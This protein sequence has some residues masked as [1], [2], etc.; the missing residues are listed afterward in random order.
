[1]KKEKSKGEIIIYKN[2]SGPGVEVWLGDETVWLSLQQIADLFGRDKSVI[3]RHIRNIFKST[4]LRQNSVVANF[5]T[6][7]AD[8][9][10]Y[11]VDYYN[12][13]M[14]ISIGYRVNSKLGTRFRVWATERLRDYILK[15][16]IVDRKRLA[17][18]QARIKELEATN[19]IFRR[20]LNSRQLTDKEKGLLKVITDYTNTW[21][22]LNKYD[23]GEL[24]FSGVSKKTPLVLKLEEARK[25]IEH[26]K[27]RLIAQKQATDIFGKESNHKLDA[28]LGSIE[29]GF[30]G[31]PAYPS[32]EERAA[33][34]LYFAIKDHPFIDGNKRIGSLLFLLY[35]IENN[36]FFAKNGESK[37]DDNALTAL[38][39]LVAESHPKQKDTI[40]KL[41]V[42]L[43]K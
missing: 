41:I 25:S 16:Y 6:T 11:Q 21:V 14:I 23:R 31:K 12:L 7:A 33:H 2:P 37:I 13:D 9:K 39:L 22:T 28:V 24:D 36:H 19:Q 15:G 42:N 3:S 27:K 29:Q 40:V 35:L 10:I 26:L 20:V 30:G 4:E 38:A 8:G 5:A 32:I 17:E 1:M 43:I 18:S 34:L